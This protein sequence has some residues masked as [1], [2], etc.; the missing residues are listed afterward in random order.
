MS[1]EE[2]EARLKKLQDLYNK[3]L[4]TY[5]EYEQKKKEILDEL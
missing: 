3:S 1:G 2:A 5:E 4:I